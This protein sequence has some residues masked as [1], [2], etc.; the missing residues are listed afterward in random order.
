MQISITNRCSLI[1]DGIEVNDK[2]NYSLHFYLDEGVIKPTL[3]FKGK[4]VIESW[5]ITLIHSEYPDKFGR[6]A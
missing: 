6:S 1:V 2:W 4:R 5:S 3:S